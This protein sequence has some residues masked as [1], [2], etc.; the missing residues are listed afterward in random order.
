M[1]STGAPGILRNANRAMRSGSPAEVTDRPP[2][3]MR[4]VDARTLILPRERIQQLRGAGHPAP[5]TP[6]RI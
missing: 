6:G 3:D 1:A 2:R 4:D 5:R